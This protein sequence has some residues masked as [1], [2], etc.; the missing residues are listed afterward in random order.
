MLHDGKTTISRFRGRELEFILN[1]AK[2]RMEY[3]IKNDILNIIPISDRVCKGKS[4]LSNG[5][6]HRNS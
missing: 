5:S 2:S 6:F 1:V 4:I 3:T